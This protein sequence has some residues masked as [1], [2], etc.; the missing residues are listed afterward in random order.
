MFVKVMSL[1]QIVHGMFYFGY[2]W[3]P[4]IYTIYVLSVAMRYVYKLTHNEVIQLNLGFH[5]DL[6]FIASKFSRLLYSDS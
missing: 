3:R 2:I 6:R 4:F 5:N 1:F